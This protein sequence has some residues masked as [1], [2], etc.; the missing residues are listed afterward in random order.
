VRGVCPGAV[1][2]REQEHALDAFAIR[3]DWIL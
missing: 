1:E 3:R 2:R